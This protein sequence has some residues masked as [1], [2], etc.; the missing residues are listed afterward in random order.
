MKTVCLDALLFKYYTLEKAFSLQAPYCFLPRLATIVC[1]LVYCIVNMCVCVRVCVCGTSV[2]TLHK[3]KHHWNSRR[4][5][6]IRY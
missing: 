5:L 3:Y 6:R 4:F 1:E 2:N